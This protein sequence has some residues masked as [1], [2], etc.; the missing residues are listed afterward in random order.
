ML[1]ALP[2][3]FHL[4]QGITGTTFRIEAFHDLDNF[5]L[6]S[7]HEP[8]R[9]AGFVLAAVLLAAFW[10]LIHNL[11]PINSLSGLY[12]SFYRSPAN[13]YRQHAAVMQETFVDFVV[14]DSWWNADADISTDAISESKIN[15]DTSCASGNRLYVDGDDLACESAGTFPEDSINSSSV[16]FN[17]TC[18]PGYHLYVVDGDL[19][20]ELDDDTEYSEDTP[21]L[22]LVGSTFGFSEAYLNNTID[23]RA[24]G[25]TYY[26]SDVYLY[27]NASNYFFLNDTLLN[28]T[29]DDR[30]SGVT[31]TAEELYI[32]LDGNTFRMNATYLN[33]S[34][35]AR[36]N[37]TTYDENSI[38][39]TLTDTTFGFDEAQLNATV[40]AIAASTTYFATSIETVDGTVD[41]GNLTSLSEYGDGDS[42]NVS[43]L[44]SLDFEI[45]INFTNVTDFTTIILNQWYEAEDDKNHDIEVCLWAWDESEWYCEY[46][47]LKYAD[48]FAVHTAAS[49]DASEHIGTGDQ[50]G[51]VSMKLQHD[52]EGD[53]GRAD[54]DFFLDYAVLVDGF[55]ALT[56]TTSVT[57]Q[58]VVDA[59]PNLNTEVISISNI[60]AYNFLATDWTNITLTES[61][62]SD[63][64]S[65]YLQSNPF[66]YYNLTNFDIADYYLLSN[67]FSYYNS[68]DFS[69][70]DYYL[71]SN[72]FGFYNST[73]FSISDYYEL[74]NPFGF[75]N[76]TDFS[77]SD[78]YLESNPFAF[79]NS[80]NF[81]IADY[82]ELTNPFGFY[83]STDF[84]ITDYYELSNPFGYYNST[85]PS[86]DTTYSEE[87]PYLTLAGTVFGVDDS[88]LN[89][90]IDT[91]TADFVNNTGDTMTGSLNVT[92]G[93]VSIDSTN[94]IC[95]TQACDH[96]IYYNGSATIIQ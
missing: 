31:Y 77:I 29:I 45:Y 41:D 54:H 38:Y 60:T 18:N 22:T 93:N 32:Y 57:L 96:Y 92:T 88:Y 83:N 58:N 78:Y 2:G 80:T 64:G 10:G 95:L 20:C 46:G 52:N 55:S 26:A 68:T 37:D 12:G 28:A 69:I 13:V 75:Y 81:D 42:Y 94:R 91:R 89:G 72:P 53:K 16:S 21:Y 47:A 67:P 74:S 19:A 36:E 15:F 70:S 40:E 71:E 7:S 14:S 51:N 25:L 61:Q 82:Y 86:P 27:K 34:I 33:E 73:E 50:L 63:L 62:I 35:D 8:F 56:T 11:C 49:Y 44:D 43:E 79:Y 84:S 24:S 76:S 3:Q 6:V 65:Y 87:D 90:T 5:A 4:F 39:L 1:L 23:A 17:L 66:S 59:N 30:A 9:M 85:N 48:W